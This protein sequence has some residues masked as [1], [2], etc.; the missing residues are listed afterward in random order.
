[1]NYRKMNESD[2]RRVLHY[3]DAE[4]GNDRLTWQMLEEFSGFTRQALQ[5]RGDIKG[6]YDAAKARVRAAKSGLTP[7]I[8]FNGSVPD[9]LLDELAELR[10]KVEVLE[11]REAAWRRRWYCIAFNVRQQNLVQMVDVDKGVPLSAQG[12]S[13]KQVHQILDALDKEI[14]PVA[15][16]TEE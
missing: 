4:V 6:S 12:I 8:E 13:Q 1:M 11:F 14:P 5:A 10:K 3:L 16:R 7:E 9:E 2:V 15:H